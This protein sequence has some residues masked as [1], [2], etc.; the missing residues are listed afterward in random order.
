MQNEMSMSEVYQP[1]IILHL[2]EKD[3][4]ANKLQLAGVLSGYDESVQECYQKILMRW[5]KQTLTKHNIVSYDQK[6]K[7]FSLCFELGSPELVDQA[8]ALCE[9]KIREWIEG[10]FENNSKSRVDASRRYRI[11]KAARGKC[12]LCGISAKI[13]PIDIDHIVPKSKADRYGN[14]VK[15]G[16]K[17]HVDNDQNLQALCFRCNRAKHNQDTTDFR[18]SDQKLVRDRIPE[19]I[20]Q[21]GR[22]PVTAPTY[23]PKIAGTTFRKTR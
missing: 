18:L 8:K 1:A 10:R 16:V 17:M 15:G 5:P 14:V 23:G 2:L 11:L 7:V 13:C 12:E 21:S 20:R 4:V 6:S 3:G 9:S 19:I 22:T